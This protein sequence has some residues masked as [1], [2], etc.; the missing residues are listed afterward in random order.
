MDIANRSSVEDF[1]VN[2][3]VKMRIWE[4][5]FYSNRQKN[6]QTLADLEIT[7]SDVK[8]ILNGL[9]VENFSQGPLKDVVFE[10]AEMWVFGQMVKQ[11][12]VYIKITLGPLGRSV[13]CISFHV[14]EYPMDYPFK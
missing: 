1:L 4:L 3:K 10:E 8:A 12:E 6:S 2:F 14:A 13:V 11:H 5:L 7:V 9:T